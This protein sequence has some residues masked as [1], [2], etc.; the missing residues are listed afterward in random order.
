MLDLG[1][2]GTAARLLMGVVAS[3]PM[4]AV[5]TGDAS[6]RRRPMGRVIEPLEQHGRPGDRRARAG[7]CRC[8]WSGSSAPLPITYDLP[9][10]SAQV[11]SAVLLAGL[12]R[13][14]RPR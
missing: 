1:N 2:S 10:A 3:H 12:S 7:D 4:T 13:P 14:A 8:P 5:L 11:K 6:L 9:V